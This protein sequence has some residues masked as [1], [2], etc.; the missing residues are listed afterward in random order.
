ME[1]QTN[2]NVSVSEIVKAFFEGGNQGLMRVL[3]ADNGEKS[4]LEKFVS[5]LKGAVSF[6]KVRKY[7]EQFLSIYEEAFRE[8]P[9]KKKED[10][11]LPEDILVKLYLLKSH[12]VYDGAREKNDKFKLFSQFINLLI[13]KITTYK[14]LEKAKHLF[15]AFVGYAK[16]E[17]DKK[18]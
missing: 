16:A 4:L 15:E 7:Y 14:M 3:V 11:N 9:E 18:H 10:Q 2:T 8:N 12:V 1:R 17:L 5:E 6:T 13:Q